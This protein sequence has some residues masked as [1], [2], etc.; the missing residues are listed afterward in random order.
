[1][2]I[3]IDISLVTGRHFKLAQFLYELLPHSFDYTYVSCDIEAE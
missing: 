2:T 3:A 1:M